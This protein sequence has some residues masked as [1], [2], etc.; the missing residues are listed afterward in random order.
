MTFTINS[1]VRSLSSLIWDSIIGII[2]IS[3]GTTKTSLLFCIGNKR[4]IIIGDQRAI[5]KRNIW[6]MAP[7]SSRGRHHI[8]GSHLTIAHQFFITVATNGSLRIKIWLN[9]F[10]FGRSLFSPSQLA[11]LTL[12]NCTTYGSLR[13]KIQLN[14]SNFGRSLSSP[15]QLTRLTLRNCTRRCIVKLGFYDGWMTLQSAKWILKDL[16][17]HHCL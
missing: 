14:L 1:K 8:L 11:R 3:V 17:L 5:R 15:S 7:L 2:I 9:L 6:D 13:I 4:I 10:N 12:R 16:I